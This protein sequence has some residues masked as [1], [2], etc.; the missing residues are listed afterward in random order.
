MSKTSKITS[1]LW[2]LLRQYILLMRNLKQQ[3]WI[4]FLWSLPQH[5]NNV[6]KPTQ[7]ELNDNH[8]FPCH[9]LFCARIWCCLGDKSACSCA[10]IFEMIDRD[11]LSS[12]PAEIFLAADADQCHMYSHGYVVS[13]PQSHMS[14][15]SYMIA[16]PPASWEENTDTPHRTVHELYWLR[17]K[18]LFLIWVSRY[19]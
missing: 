6:T 2:E 10:L 17:L 16:L 9:K 18:I 13:W 5:H 11:L 14:P 12:I 7:A 4:E 19:I 15:I 3:V 1:R 8:F